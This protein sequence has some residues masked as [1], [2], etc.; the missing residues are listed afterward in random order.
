VRGQE[1]YEVNIFS[2]QVSGACPDV[3]QDYIS[4]FIPMYIGKEKLITIN[5]LTFFL[6]YYHSFVLKEK[7][8]PAYRQA[9]AII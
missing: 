6:S 2:E 3:S 4:E 9:G 7:M 8:Q 1:K 5:P